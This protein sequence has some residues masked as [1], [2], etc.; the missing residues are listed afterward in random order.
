MEVEM[1]ALKKNATWELVDLPKGK[2]TMG[3]KCMYTVN[4]KADESLERYK[5]RLVAK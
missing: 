2:K 5:A 1:D 4:H 3:C